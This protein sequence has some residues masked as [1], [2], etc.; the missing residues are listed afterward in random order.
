MGS[1]ETRESLIKAAME[2]LYS[3]QDAQKITARQIAAAANL[4]HAMINYCCKSKEELLRLAAERIVE[5]NFAGIKAE[6][7]EVGTPRERIRRALLHTAEQ[8]MAYQNLAQISVPY[9]LLQEEIV[10]P[11]TI[12]PYLKEHFGNRR[13]ETECKVIAYQLISFLQLTLLRA[14]AFYR[15]AGIDVQKPE[16]VEQ[17]LD[18]QLTLLLG[19]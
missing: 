5:E 14:E 16:Q 12:L 15:Y 13:T 4:N 6:A 18:M 10:V 19:E 1:D 9:I 3:S 7:A 17:L 11:Y 2:L 8:T